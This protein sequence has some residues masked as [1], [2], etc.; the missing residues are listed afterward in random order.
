MIKVKSVYY[1]CNDNGT[2]KII[3]YDNEN[4]MYTEESY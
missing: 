4:K 3:I 1:R 2:E